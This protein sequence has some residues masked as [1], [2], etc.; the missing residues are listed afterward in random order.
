MRNKPLSIVTAVLACLMLEAIL[1]W[2]ETA[3]TVRIPAE[4]LE[5]QNPLAGQADAVPA[6]Q[7]LYMKNCSHCHG[8]NAGGEGKAANLLLPRIHDARPGQ[9]FWWIRNGNLP[10]GMPAWSHLSDGR[11]WQIV[12]Y[13][14]SLPPVGGGNETNR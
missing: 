4:D 12:T 7:K 3:R 2:G 11:I 14:Q 9:L 5:R 13:L 8:K 6:G 1:S 10:R